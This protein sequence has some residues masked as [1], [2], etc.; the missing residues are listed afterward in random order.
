MVEN[1]GTLSESTKPEALQVY[2]LTREQRTC[3]P[4]VT[5]LAQYIPN[6]L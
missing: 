3:V 2:I 6:T 4:H 1:G 5:Q